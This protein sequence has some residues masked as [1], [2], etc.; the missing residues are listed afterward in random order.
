MDILIPVM[1]SISTDL[2]SPREGE[3]IMENVK[4]AEMI[5]AEAHKNQVDKGG[6][7]YIEHPKAVAAG[8]T[9]ELEKTVAWLHDVVEDTSFTLEDIESIFGNTVRDAVDAITR[10]EGEDRTAYLERVRANKTATAV[11]LS[12]L[13]HNSDLSRISNRPLEEKD[14]ERVKKYKAEIQLL[15]TD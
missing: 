10:R 6:H 8:V 7:P 4:L 3:I 1:M 11:K 9:T 12:D 15:N 13:R 14:Y 2:S 5:A